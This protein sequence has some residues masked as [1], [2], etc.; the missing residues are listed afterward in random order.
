M[1]YLQ[2]NNLLKLDV[3]EETKIHLSGMAQWGNI[4]AIISFVNLG[5]GLITTIYSIFLLS[6]F[7]NYAAGISNLIGYLFTA[8]IS[9]LLNITLFVAAKNLKAGI[10]GNE[11]GQFNVGIRKLNSFFRITGILFIIVM[12]IT[13][14]ATIIGIIIGATGMYNSFR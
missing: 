1:D 10:E 2:E 6:K 14:L 3:T 4:Y 5:L 13:L 7:D 8:A 11:Q 12:V 9:L